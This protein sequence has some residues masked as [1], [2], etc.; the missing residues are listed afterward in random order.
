MSSSAPPSSP[1]PV[2]PLPSAGASAVPVSAS[3]SGASWVLALAL[4][5]ALLSLAISAMLWQ[6]LDAA[7]QELARQSQESL[8]KSVEARTLAGQAE[9]LTQELQAR[10]SVAEVRLSEVSLQRTQLEELMLALSRTRDDT[11]VEEIESALRLAQQQVQLT[12]STQPLVSALQAADQRIGRAAQPRLNPVQRAIARDIDRI[13]SA[14][15]AD[16][17]SLALRLDELARQVDEWPVINEVGPQSAAPASAEGPV[18]A[19]DRTSPPKA[20]TVPA[21]AAAEGPPSDAGW[22]ETLR[23]WGTRVVTEVLRSGR[24]LV[25]VSRIDHPEAVLLA[26]EQAFFLRENLK[27]KLLNARLALL[28]RHMGAAQTDLAAIDAALR[29][30]FDGRTPAVESARK[31]V[32][33]VREA[34]LVTELPR[35]DESLAALAVAAGGR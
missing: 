16:I 2:S 8:S 29:R 18:V 10:L 6:R 3:R 14:S 22:Q 25:R 26:P 5:V 32:A 17:P 28:A 33:Q 13:R 27:L 9:A 20:D 19:P 23:A 7:R 30:Y 11:L 4:L 1:P 24:D 15:V 34:L 31:H 12:G 21:Q 35:P